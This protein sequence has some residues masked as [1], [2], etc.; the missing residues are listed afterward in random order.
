[1]SANQDLL[2]LMLV[3]KANNLTQTVFDC[4]VV[5][6]FTFEEAIGILSGMVEGLTEAIEEDP[7]KRKELIKR[8]SH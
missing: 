6:K 3:A 4:L 7:S 5:N 2:N 8:V 1:M